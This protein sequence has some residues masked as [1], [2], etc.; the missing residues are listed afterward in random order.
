MNAASP[1]GDEGRACLRR[2]DHALRAQRRTRAA[3]RH[4]LGQG[5]RDGERR[6]QQGDVC[7]EGQPERPRRV[8][9]QDSRQQGPAPQAAHVGGGGRESRPRA[10][11]G[12]ASSS[13]AAVPAPLSSPA[14]KPDSRRPA[15]SSG[16]PFWN[17]KHTALSRD[18]PSAVSSTGRLP[19]TSE[20]SPATS[21]A[22][23]TPI[24]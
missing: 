22:A 24:A 5:T 3:D 23:I 12:G 2:D 15:N 6:Q 20:K 14:E 8:L 9:R 10:Q 18:S 11:A 16:R 21:R 13:T 19:R 4:R 17:R 7:H 1:A